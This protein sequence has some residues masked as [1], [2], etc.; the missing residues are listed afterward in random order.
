MFK[1]FLYHAEFEKNKSN[2]TVAQTNGFRHYIF[3]YVI[4]VRAP[5]LIFS[6]NICSDITHFHFIR[7]DR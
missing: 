2:W 5:D 7:S 3:S 4:Y 6:C 1:V